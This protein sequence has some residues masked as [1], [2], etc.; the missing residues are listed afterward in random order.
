MPASLIPAV[1]MLLMMP[2]AMIPVMTAMTATAMI[3]T[4]LIPVMAMM[5][6][7]LPPPTN[8]LLCDQVVFGCS[9]MFGYDR[10]SV[11]KYCLVQCAMSSELVR[12]LEE[13]LF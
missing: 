1:H 10:E 12:Q 9:A 11:V 6:T 7:W 4:A 8:A 5:T 13:Q 2:T 3:P